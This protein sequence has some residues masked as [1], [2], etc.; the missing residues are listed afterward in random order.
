MPGSLVAPTPYNLSA[1]ET[2]VGGQPLGCPGFAHAKL[3][4]Q[5]QLATPAGQDF[6]HGGFQLS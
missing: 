2:G 5:S 1:P 4:H 6:P 3:P